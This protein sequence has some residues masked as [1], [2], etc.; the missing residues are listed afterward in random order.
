MTYTASMWLAYHMRVSV[1][2]Y[3]TVSC[4]E[5]PTFSLASTKRR[6]RQVGV[7]MLCS[8]S[9]IS[10]SERTITNLL[11]SLGLPRSGEHRGHGLRDDVES[12]GQLFGGGGQGRQELDDFALRA[13]GLHLQPPVERLRAHLR[14]RRGVGEGQSLGETAPAGPGDRVGVGGGDPAA[15][16]LALLALGVGVFFFVFVG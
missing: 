5:K 6:L 3:R 4:I 1:P 2:A 12:F 14:R 7:S 16:A 11:P 15:R 10:L 13:G 9:L 8:V